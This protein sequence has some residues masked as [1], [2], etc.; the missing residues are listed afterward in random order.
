MTNRELAAVLRRWSEIGPR[1]GERV[2]APVPWAPAARLIAAVE[3]DAERASVALQ[4]LMRAT[5]AEFP[6]VGYDPLHVDFHTHRWLKKEHELAYS[7]WL[8]WILDQRNDS[9]AVLSLLGRDPGMLAGTP[10]TPDEPN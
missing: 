6:G 1:L 8:A 3:R 7:D 2:L 9:G 5:A 4:G 10:C